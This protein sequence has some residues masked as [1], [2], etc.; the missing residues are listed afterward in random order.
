M[1]M[2]RNGV[3]PKGVDGCREQLDSNLLWCSVGH[4]I[5]LSAALAV[6]HMFLV[7]LRRGFELSKFI[8]TS[9][10]GGCPDLLKPSSSL[11]LRQLERINSLN[12]LSPSHQE[13]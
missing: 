3:V 5:V 8:R 11:L 9:F 1:V 12:K 2:R 7:P 10:F 4:A 6:I 13:N